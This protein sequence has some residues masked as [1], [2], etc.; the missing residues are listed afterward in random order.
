[1]ESIQNGWFL[2]KEVKVLTSLKGNKIIGD[3]ILREGKEMTEMTNS[4][5]QTFVNINLV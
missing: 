3:S 2:W 5:K 4:V 1:M